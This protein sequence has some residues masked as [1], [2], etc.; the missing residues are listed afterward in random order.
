[1]TIDAIAW[2]VRFVQDDKGS[3]WP[4]VDS[5]WVTAIMPTSFQVSGKTRD[6]AARRLLVVI[7]SAAKDL[8]MAPADIDGVRTIPR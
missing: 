2:V 3:R 8:C 6:I 5:R 4:L 1:V 7:L